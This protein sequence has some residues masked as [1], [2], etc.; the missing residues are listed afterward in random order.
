MPDDAHAVAR[1][2]DFGLRKVSRLTW[3]AGAAG[4]A[5]SAVIGLALAH[6][7]Q[8]SSAVP[9]H[10]SDPGGIVIPAQPPMPS[11]GSGQVVSGAS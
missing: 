9:E 7:A 2:R 4:V 1:D 11:Q 8:A 5:F 3:R 6:H 10:R